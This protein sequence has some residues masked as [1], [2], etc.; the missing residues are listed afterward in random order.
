MGGGLRV[1]GQGTSQNISLWHRIHGVG[2]AKWNAQ[3]KCV[4]ASSEANH[5]TEQAFECRA[6]AVIVLNGTMINHI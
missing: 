5:S 2:N 1:R 4:K 6:T 3:T